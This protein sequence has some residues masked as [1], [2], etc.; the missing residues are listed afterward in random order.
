ML[1][2]LTTVVLAQALTVAYC[3]CTWKRGSSTWKRGSIKIQTFEGLQSMRKLG[4]SS[5]A[6]AE[7]VHRNWQQR[8][9]A[10]ARATADGGQED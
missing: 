2:R 1:T 7:S 4:K 8:Q 5:S 3:G 6:I 10:A 9:D